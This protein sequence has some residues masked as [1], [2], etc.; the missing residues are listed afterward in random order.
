MLE[1][2]KLQKL[3]TTASNMSIIESPRK[4]SDIPIRSEALDEM[5]G[6]TKLTTRKKKSKGRATVQR[7]VANARI[8]QERCRQICLSLF[9][10]EREPIQSLGFTSS[11]PGEGKSFLATVTA[12]VLANDSSDP[13][14]LME[15]N[16]ENPTLHEYFDCPPTP[17]LAEWLRGECSVEEI[18]YQINQRLTVIPAGNGKRDA[19]QLL[20]RVRREGLLNMP[21]RAKD[22]VIVDLPS[23]ATTAYGSLAASL[24]DAVI[25][26]VH[27]GVT[28]AALI[29]ET[30]SQ[31]KDLSVQGL[32]LNQMESKIPRW[33]RRLL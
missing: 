6:T 27:A 7:D 29:A 2:K 17:G 25:V 23:T 18:R 14:T 20:Q 24:V 13:I 26:V 21:I 3:S 9:F 30:C 11:I 1:D 12:T 16:W 22:L 28:P 5:T 4:A 15:C 31:L 8:L 19:V 32:I 33:I 10:R